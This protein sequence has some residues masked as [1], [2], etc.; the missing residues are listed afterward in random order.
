[1]QP[2]EKELLKN[3]SYFV[4]TPELNNEVESIIA[5]EETNR[6]ALLIYS[7]APVGKNF[8]FRN[9]LS[10]K[11]GHKI[12]INFNDLSYMSSFPAYYVVKTIY[13]INLSIP[14]L[15]TKSATL[16]QNSSGASPT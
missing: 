6:E 15:R 9:A 10:K 8:A 1:M 14:L 3:N 7:L 5:L 4:D 16:L 11:E 12:F 13:P 2:F